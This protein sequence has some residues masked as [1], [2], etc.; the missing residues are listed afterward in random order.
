MRAVTLEGD[1][2]SPSGTL[3]GGS[4]SRNNC[5]LRELSDLADTYARVEEIDRRLHQIE[6]MLHRCG[7]SAH[8]SGANFSGPQPVGTASRRL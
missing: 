7:R 1:D 6:G 5:V 3:T 4:R 2:V 8:L